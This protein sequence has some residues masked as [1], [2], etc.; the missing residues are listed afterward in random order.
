MR[1]A[2]VDTGAIEGLY[3]VDRGFTISVISMATAWVAE[4]EREKGSDVVA[5]VTAQR[6]AYDLALDAATQGT[7]ISEA[8]IRSLHEAVCAAQATYEVLTP[9]GPQQHELPRGAYKRYSNHV[10]KADGSTHAH[11]P[12]EATPDQMHRLVEAL[13][14]AAFLSAHPVVQAAYAHYALT[15]IHPFADGN[16]RVARV[17]ASTYLLRAVS[18]P[19]VVYADQKGAYLDALVA[20]DEGHRQAFVHFVMS[21]VVDLQ[22]DLAERLTTALTP[23]VEESLSRVRR[24]F[25]SHGGLGPE[26]IDLIGLRLF[27]EVRN[28]LRLQLDRVTPPTGVER[29]VLV[30]STAG[31]TV[32]GFRALPHQPATG[33]LVRA[34]APAP[35]EVEELLYVHIATRADEAW[36]FQVKRRGHAD[37]LEIR[38][39]ELHPVV[40]EAFRARLSNWV[41]RIVR[42]SLADFASLV[43]GAVAKE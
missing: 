7:H 17:L 23:S 41:E 31:D 10:R 34:M 16:G 40:H 38:L 20:A 5:L 14:S 6:Q 1:A 43:E 25:T 15:A 32:P 8:W 24:A 42:E 3:T 18:L 21:Q 9:Q 29:Q 19:L 13:R 35:V 22:R 39:A 12:A 36:P 2:S 4:I 28:S 33:F 26:E 11:A 27:E 37:G 30:A